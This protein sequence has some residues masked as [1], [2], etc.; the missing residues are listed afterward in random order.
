M[1]EKNEQVIGFGAGCFWGVEHAFKQL[2]GVVKTEVGYQGGSSENP[3]YEEVCGKETGHAEVVQV[4]FDPSVVTLDRLL[5]AFFFM[6]DPTQLNRQGPD[7]GPQ[8]RSVIFP[9]HDIMERQVSEYIEFTAKKKFGEALVTTIEKAPFF[10][11][12]N[13]HQDYLANNPGGYCHIGLD[14]FQKLRQ[15]LF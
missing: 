6:H 2:D 4:T 9:S 12:E 13:F 5:D 10:S 1:S 7:V 3:T 14:V 11:A 15:G 8:Y